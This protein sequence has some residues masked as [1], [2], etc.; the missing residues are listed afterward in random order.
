MN[1][2]LHKL[3]KLGGK[4]KTAPKAAPKFAPRLLA[5]QAS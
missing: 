1:F 2:D 3:D 5:K 4:G